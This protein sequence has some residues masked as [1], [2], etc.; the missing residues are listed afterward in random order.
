[1]LIVALGCLWGEGVTQPLKVE[2]QAGK[3]GST[4]QE[5]KARGKLIA[6]VTANEPPLGFVDNIK[7]F[8]G[9]YID[10]AGSLAK[11]IFD[12][13]AKVEFIG[14]PIEEWVDSLNSRKVDL[15][16]AP[17]FISEDKGN[18]IDYTIPCFVSGGVILVRKDGKIRSYQDLSGRNVATIRGTTAGT[19][20]R[21][22]VPKS[23]VVEFRNNAEALQALNGKNVDA[24]AQ[25]DLFGFYMEEKNKN[26]TVL[27]LRPV[28]PSPIRLGVKKGDRAW[29]DFV[30]IA[31]LKMMTTGEYRKLLDKWFGRVRGGLLESALK[32]EM[33]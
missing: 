16:L 28:R 3:T 12:G 5:V 7:G 29:R 4:L 27:D 15:L 11:R 23:N 19:M 25:L 14:V 2:N 18:E 9:F 20:I 22:L 30:D 10:V 21:E 17:L 13:E 8:Q 6:G 33:K 1:M 32:N 31:L 26:L 24:F